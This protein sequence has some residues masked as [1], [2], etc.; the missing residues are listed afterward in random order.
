MTE[1]ERAVRELLRSSEEAKH[2]LKAVIVPLE[3]STSNTDADD[4]Q[5]QVDGSQSRITLAL[6]T[7][8]DAKP[9]REEGWYVPH[10]FVFGMP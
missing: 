4:G 8:K 7:H 10:L 3:H 1:H 2:I 6:V 9:G 5:G